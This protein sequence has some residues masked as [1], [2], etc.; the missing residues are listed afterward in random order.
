MMWIAIPVVVV[1]LILGLLAILS[2]MPFGKKERTVAAPKIAQVKDAEPPPLTGTIRELP[3]QSP[4]K[5]G[6]AE[7]T[8]LEPNVSGGVLPAP[9][10]PQPTAGQP[11]TPQPTQPS[12]APVIREEAPVPSS[13]PPAPRESSGEREISEE[14]AVATLQGYLD[15]RKVYDLDDSCI[16]VRSEG[17]SNEGYTLLVTD[18]CD[19]GS[20]GRWRVDAKNRE[21]YR[22]R[23]DGKYRRP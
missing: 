3:A 16:G 8:I 21:L 6:E 4:A 11:Q 15:A 22:Q 9:P 20:I 14:E 17:Y 10:P 13:P 5:P 12:P 2:G 18:R 19:G 1:L 23:A 7:F